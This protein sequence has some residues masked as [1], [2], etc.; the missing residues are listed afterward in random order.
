M[1]ATGIASETRILK[2]PSKAKEREGVDLTG[3]KKRKRERKRERER[4]GGRKE[5]R[6]KRRKG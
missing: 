2:R 5:E 4:E 6:K 3:R 1:S